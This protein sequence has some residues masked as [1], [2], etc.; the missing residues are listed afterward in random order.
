MNKIA[1]R[2]LAS[3]GLSVTSLSLGTVPL[4]GFGS[5]TTFQDFEDVV[6]DAINHCGIRYIDT[7][8]MYGSTRSEHFLGHL[9]RV[10]ELRSSVVVSTKAGRL[11]RPR[12]S[13]K[14]AGDV[15][16]GVSWLGELPFV[17]H[18]D[19]SYDGIMRSFQDTQQ[20][21][22]LDQL[23]VLLVHDIGRMV[24][25]DRNAHYWKQLQDGGFK[26]LDELRSSGVIKAVGIGVNECE[27]VIEMA[28]EFPIDCCLV[29][30][31]YTLLD[32]QA[33]DALYPECQKR[34]IAVIA[35]GVFNSGILGGG[36]TGNTR[37]YNYSD[38]PPEILTKVKQ[39][40]EVCREFDVP[41]PSAA[42][43][44]VA[45]NPAV[46]TVLQGAKS[47][48]ELRQNVDAL[49]RPIAPAFW[50]RLKER[51]VLARGAPTP[52]G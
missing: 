43:Q 18:F 22:G 29:A 49:T 17:E 35:A 3:T 16:F 28:R 48:A 26:A 37:T 19:Y 12:S 14:Q 41:L 32:Q 45:A 31:R 27:A 8:P 5:A 13:V 46:T 42:V 2:P 20:R 24:H 47:V 38:V 25:G 6:L 39:I 30:G 21:F 36:S 7:A 1:S 33:M 9:L 23:D 4:S 44:F 10:K 50:E 11:M 51:G 34:G 40:E 15:V 52:T